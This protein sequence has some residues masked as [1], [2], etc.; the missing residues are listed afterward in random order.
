MNICSHR[1]MTIRLD[2]KQ[3]GYKTSTNL[4][5]LQRECFLNSVHLDW[6]YINECL[7]SPLLNVRGAACRGVRI[8][9]SHIVGSEVHIR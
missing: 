8:F 5:L 4:G 9:T 3:I 2:T 1:M 6:T 7:F